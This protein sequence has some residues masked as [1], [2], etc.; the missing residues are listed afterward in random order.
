M[1]ICF[2]GAD[3]FAEGDA[4]SVSVPLYLLALLTI[5]Q[6]ILDAVPDGAG[7]VIL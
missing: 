6:K 4:F 3:A 7:G 5:L 1:Q 2:A